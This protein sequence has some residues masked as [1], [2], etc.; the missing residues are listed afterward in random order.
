[1][2][3][4]EAQRARLDS[5]GEGGLLPP[6]TDGEAALFLSAISRPWQALYLSTRDA[7][8][9]GG[10]AVPSQLWLRS[11]AIFGLPKEHVDAHRTLADQVFVAV[12][13]PT[14]RHLARTQAACARI[15]SRQAGEGAFKSW[16]R[17]T[18]R[19]CAPAILA[20]LATRDVF[21][22]SELEKHLRCPFAWFLEKVVGAKDLEI[23]FDGMVI[24]GIMHEALKTTYRE[25]RQ[26][27]MLPLRSQHLP[28]AKEV[29]F[30]AVDKA[31]ARD[32]VAGASAEK[33]VSA[34][35]LKRMIGEMLR[36]ESE[37]GSRMA[38]VDTEASIGGYEGVDIGGLRLRGRIDRVDADSSGKRLFVL[39]YKSGGIPSPK[40]LGTEEGLQLPLYL[41]ALTA[42]NP[43]A[44]V[45]G[46]AYHSLKNRGRSGVVSVDAVD[47]LGA[48]SEGCLQVDEVGE[49]EL[50]DTTLRTATAAADGIRSGIIAPQAGKACPRWCDLGPICRARKGNG[51]W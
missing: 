25:L 19:L 17:E 6:D 13:A 40:K 10:A 46:G 23:E 31:V 29:A 15:S 24:G 47:L 4:T 21:S 5:L 44:R 33:V 12:E 27:G 32:D 45:I 34:F 38:M 1:M 20:E 42:D 39:D 26:A 43:Q 14:P 48:G 11:R 2:L 30:A 41:M 16:Y 49:Q 18:P 8:D 7:D 9:G 50:F 51:G 37:S 28:R 22:P 36:W 3:L 35:R